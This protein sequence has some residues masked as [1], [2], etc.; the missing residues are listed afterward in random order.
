MCAAIRGSFAE[1][2]ILGVHGQRILDH[3]FLAGDQVKSQENVLLAATA[4]G[5]RLPVA[6]LVTHAIALHYLVGFPNAD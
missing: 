1:S 2:Q 5:A 3:N 4:G 6:E